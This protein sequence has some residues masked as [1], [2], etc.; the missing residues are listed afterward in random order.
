[1]TKFMRFVH[2]EFPVSLDAVDKTVYMPLDSKQT[3]YHEALN[4]YLSR[5]SIVVVEQ[6]I[7]FTKEQRAKFQAAIDE[8]QNAVVVAPY[9]LY[10]CSTALPAPVWSPRQIFEVHNGFVFSARWV[11][12]NDEYCDAFG[13]GMTYIPSAL[14]REFEYEKRDIQR[15]LDTRFSE[16]CISKKLRAKIVW[17]VIPAHYHY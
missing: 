17:E 14:W 5:E 7:D 16:F 3:Y 10:P 12:F 6:D 13:L 15:D 9:V 4:F 11:N 2:K 1:M 8:N